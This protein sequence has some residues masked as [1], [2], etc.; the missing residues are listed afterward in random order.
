MVVALHAI[1]KL[2]TITRCSIDVE[3][4]ISYNAQDHN[5]LG[6]CTFLTV[7]RYFDR[8]CTP[9]FCGPIGVPAWITRVVL[10]RLLAK[11]K[12]DV[13]LR[14]RLT[15]LDHKLLHLPVPWALPKTKQA[16]APNATHKVITPSATILVHDD[17]HA[18]NLAGKAP[19]LSCR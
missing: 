2:D 7:I 1:V 10:R 5:T 17:L 9:V 12:C 8:I 11:R 14:S 18:C 19:V 4:D 15:H 6:K 13:K 3:Y 16:L